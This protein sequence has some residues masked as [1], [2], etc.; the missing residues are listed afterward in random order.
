[1]GVDVSSW[2]PMIVYL[3]AQKLDPT[4]FNEYTKE[5]QKSRELPDLEEFLTFL[6]NTFLAFET[7]KGCQKETTIS[8]NQTS[9]KTI[10]KPFNKGWISNKY[11]FNANKPQYMKK[12]TLYEHNNDHSNTFH[13][14]YGQCPLCADDH[15]LMQCDKF[16]SW[17]NETKRLL[18]SRFAK[19]VYTAMEIPF[20]LLGKHAENAT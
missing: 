12:S 19:T 16:L 5:T 2:G 13:T 10:A 11:N 3:M 18:N 8:Q 15:V 6:E 9:N 1:M 20:V 4:T 7:A 17:D 14:S